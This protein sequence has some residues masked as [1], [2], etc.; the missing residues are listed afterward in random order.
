MAPDCVYLRIEIYTAPIAQGN[1]PGIGALASVTKRDARY[2][3]KNGEPAKSGVPS[4]AIVIPI[5]F[6][7][8]PRDFQAKGSAY[9]IL[10]QFY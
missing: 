1:S 7:D 2:E 8:L 5:V 10:L 9:C 6:C 3:I 4:N